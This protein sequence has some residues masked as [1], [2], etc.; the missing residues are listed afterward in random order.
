MLIISHEAVTY[1]HITLDSYIA[2]NAPETEILDVIGTKVLRFFHLAFHSHL[3][4]RILH[5]RSKK[6]LKIMP[7]N[8]NEIFCALYADVF[9]CRYSRCR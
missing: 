3:Y 4:Y 6:T 8:L 1:Q 9:S 2:R 5:I 7:R